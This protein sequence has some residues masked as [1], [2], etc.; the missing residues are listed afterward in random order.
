MFSLMCVPTHFNQNCSNV[1][2]NI[3]ETPQIRNF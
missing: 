1:F 2:T 3:S